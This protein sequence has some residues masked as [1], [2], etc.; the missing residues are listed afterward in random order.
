MSILPEKFDSVVKLFFLVVKIL[1]MEIKHQK[2]TRQKVI[3]LQEE[4]VL[5]IVRDHHE[6][7]MQST[8]R[9]VVSIFGL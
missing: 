8:K 2:A 1:K 5:G 7:V 9:L 3:G 4:V 6:T